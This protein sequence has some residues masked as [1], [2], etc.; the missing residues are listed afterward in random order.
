MLCKAVVSIF[1][2]HL[3]ISLGDW[4][5]IYIIIC[6]HCITQL[7]VFGFPWVSNLS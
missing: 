4:Y 3:N 1:N 5:Y 2:T 7:L 6:V